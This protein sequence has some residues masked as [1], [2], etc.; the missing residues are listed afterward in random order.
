MDKHDELTIGK[1]YIEDI[2]TDLHI[3]YDC[4]MYIT[5]EP[6][7]DL[8]KKFIEI[9]EW[10]ILD[11]FDFIINSF[12]SVDNSYIGYTVINNLYKYVMAN[13]HKE[14][15]DNDLTHIYNLIKEIQNEIF[16][17]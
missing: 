6:S 8:C 9:Y 7:H 12:E 4:D 10:F 13:Y 3:L 2:L 16:N 11:C 1:Q 15:S 5:H 17:R 14:L